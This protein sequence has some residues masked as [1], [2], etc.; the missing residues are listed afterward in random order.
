MSTALFAFVPAAL[1]P[2][3]DLQ[4]SQINRLGGVTCRGRLPGLDPRPRGR[5]ETPDL[6]DTIRSQIAAQQARWRGQ[7]G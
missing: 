6:L 3:G 5:E 1:V 7:E 2:M 4:V